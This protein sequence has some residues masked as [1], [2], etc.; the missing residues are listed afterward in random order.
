MLRRSDALNH[1]PKPSFKTEVRYMSGINQDIITVLHSNLP[2][3]VRQTREISQ[4]FKGGS[5]L[6]TA[7][8][9]WDFLKREIRYQRDR[10]GYQDIKLP[11]RFVAEGTGDCKS[12]S[13]FTAAILDN[14]GI[15]FKFRYTSYTADKT[16]QHVYIVTDSGII[17]DAVWHS[18]NTQ[19]TFTHKKDYSMQISTLS[20][21]GCNNCNNSNINGTVMIGDIGKF[22]LKKAAQSVKSAVKKTA[23]K[24]QDAAKNTGVV[25]VAAKAQTKI[26]TGASN[27]QDKAKN[28]G[29]IRAAAKIQDKAKNL[30]GKAI[31]LAAPRRAYR[32]LVAVNFRGWASKLA[33]NIPGAKSIWERAGGSWYEF[34]KSI[35]AGKDRKALFGSSTQQIKTVDGIGS[36]T[37]AT[38]GTLLALAAPLIA[39]FKGLTKDGTG[40]P[41]GSYDASGEFS[42]GAD[43]GNILTDILDKVVDVFK[44]A[45]GGENTDTGSGQTQTSPQNET[46]AESGTSSNTGL[47]LLAAAA[48]AYFISK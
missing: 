40:A 2:R 41:E 21:I 46:P 32:T 35:N 30:T 33:A 10:D 28:T 6:E 16:P 19:K 23:S 18:F 17:I 42:P 15:P 45:G 11:G 26:K 44:G 39:L 25:K 24:V 4:H 9:I 8:K 12:Y 22:S 1:L 14:L 47:Y 3:A 7:R 27:I 37:L 5:D 38:I 13:L 29:I 36:A 20:G 31:A 34:E 48:G 43:E